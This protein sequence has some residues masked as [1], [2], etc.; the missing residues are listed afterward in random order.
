MGATLPAVSRWVE[1]TKAGMS[2]TGFLYA[3]NI[4]GAVFGCLLAGFDLLRVYDLRVATYTAAMINIGVALLALILANRAPSVA[5]LY[6]RRQSAVT[7]RRY[8]SVYLAIGLSGLSALGAQ[9][10][11]TRLLSL[12]LGVT[13]YTESAIATAFFASYRAMFVPT[14]FIDAGNTTRVKTFRT[15]AQEASRKSSDNERER[16]REYLLP[17][18]DGECDRKAG[19]WPGPRFF[20]Q[21]ESQASKTAGID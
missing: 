9:V 8:G 1:A 7:D 11:W 6:E 2:R 19:S 10:V 14:A 5:A 3:A 13:V 17:D 20:R 16:K 21:V 4:A 12:L 15:P 18:R